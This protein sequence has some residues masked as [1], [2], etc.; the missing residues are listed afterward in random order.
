MS[1]LNKF[2]KEFDG[3]NIGERLQAAQGP[4]QGK[5][6]GLWEARAGLTMSRPRVFCAAA[7][8]VRV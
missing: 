7:A 1:F 6:A 4:Q 3:L 2:K 5:S 8:F